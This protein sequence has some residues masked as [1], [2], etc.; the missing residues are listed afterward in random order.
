MGYWEEKAGYETQKEWE[1]ATKEYTYDRILDI[2]PKYINKVYEHI[3]MRGDDEKFDCKIISHKKPTFCKVIAI[4]K[5][6]FGQ[7]T[8]ITLNLK[9]LKNKIRLTIH[10][11]IKSLLRYYY[12]PQKKELEK[13]FNKEVEELYDLFGDNLRETT[14][15]PKFCHKCGLE[16]KENSK[17]CSDCGGKIK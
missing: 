6:F 14:K 2:N 3:I 5:G 1:D 9:K 4:Q 15:N 10:L 16:L 7:K 17:F 8:D 12:K 11:E 13:H